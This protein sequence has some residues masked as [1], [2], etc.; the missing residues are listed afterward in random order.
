[1]LRTNVVQLKEVYENRSQLGYEFTESEVAKLGSGLQSLEANVQ[2][3]LGTVD[4]ISGFR[5]EIQDTVKTY[6]GNERAYRRL[7]SIKKNAKLR[8]KSEHDEDRN[9]GRR[10]MNMCEL[11]KH[12]VLCNPCRRMFG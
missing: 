5:D 9:G 1:M 4:A 11:L 8:N 3:L 12:L 6:T 10:K 2:R 7:R